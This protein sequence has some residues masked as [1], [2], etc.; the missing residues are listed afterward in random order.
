[1][2]NII[3]RLVVRHRIFLFACAGL[4]CSFQILTS[5]IIAS[6]DLPATLEQ[7]LIFAPP[8]IRAMIEQSMLGGSN[9]GIL[10]FVW[11]HPVTHTLVTAVAI[12]LGARPVAGE[13]ENGAIEFVLAQPVSRVQYLT[14]H[15]IFAAVAM[16][17]VASAGLLGSVVGQNLFG[18]DPFPWDRI[19]RLLLNIWLL[20]M[21][22]YSLTLVFSSFGRELGRVAS[23]GVFI[24]IVS[25]LDNVIATLWNK[26]AFMEPYSLQ[27][28]YNPRDILV[29][30]NLAP[31]SILVLGVF[32]VSAIIT[33]FARFLTRDL[34]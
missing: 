14:S 1:M 25:Y 17:A 12:T 5:A 22:F 13:I 23:L 28:Y 24:A 27:T 20:K 15:L 3:R 18:L 7:F 21:T 2:L 8:A 26:A 11:N 16:L 31:Q 34:P 4:L 9:A 19:G 10:A 33:A 29:N 32:T 6:I 30:G